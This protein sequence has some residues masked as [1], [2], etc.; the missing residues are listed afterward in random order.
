ML[1]LLSLRNQEPG[2]MKMSDEIRVKATRCED[3]WVFPVAI[4]LWN[5]RNNRIRVYAGE[6]DPYIPGWLALDQGKV[7]FDDLAR[8]DRFRNRMIRRVMGRDATA[9]NI[10]Y[11]RNIVKLYRGWRV[12]ENMIIKGSWY[13]SLGS[14]R[15]DG[16]YLNLKDEYIHELLLHGSDKDVIHFGGREAYRKWYESVKKDRTLITYIQDIST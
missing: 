2:D 8:A 4:D 3:R 14:K 10:C 1:S 5:E 11:G 16:Q 9:S 15:F 12:F 13:V 7:R 6:I